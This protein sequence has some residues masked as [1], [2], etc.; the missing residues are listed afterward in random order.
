M[1]KSKKSK[2]L[3]ILILLLTIISCKNDMK[4]NNENSLKTYLLTNK[5]NC[6]VEVLNFGATVMS[7]EVPD[8]NGNISNI[9]L[10]YD[11][12]EEYIEG[13]PYFG[14][15]I[16]R[17]GNRIAKGKFSLNKKDYQLAKNNGNNHLH[18]GPGGFHNVIWN[19][20]DYKNDNENH[21]IKLKYFSIDNE[22]G[23]PGNLT[24]Y[25]KYTLSE[26][27]ELIIDY[28]ASC[29]TKTIVNLTHHSFFNLKDA[30]KSTILNHELKINADK[31][32]P[33]NSELIPTGKIT[34][35][36][37]SSMDFTTS[38]A[39]GKRINE[40]FE[41]LHFG[42]GYDHNWVLIQNDSSLNLAAEVYEPVTGRKMEVYTTEPGLQFYSG[43]FLDGSDIGKDSTKYQ[44]RTAFCLEAQHFPDSP[45]HDNFPSTILN[46]GEK[47]KQKTI[48]KFSIV[49]DRE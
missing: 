2:L 29:D 10:G 8:K 38:V 16:G 22:E 13:N 28:E 48:Y 9:V 46:P 20:E 12:P 21:Y 43:N 36:K 26:N 47:Y 49:N 34:Y 24:V 35:V 23:Y 14:A 40:D 41:Q 4:K 5:N 11:N 42:K 39:I 44:F 18:G 37:S 27:N 1:K 19:V 25:V 6:C 33:V 32:I 3:T 31:Y 7:I 17:Y 15:I 30:G 45:N